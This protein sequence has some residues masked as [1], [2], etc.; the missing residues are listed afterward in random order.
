VIIVSNTSPL[1]NLAAI[2]QFHLL[3]DL[4]G[5]LLIANGVWSELNAYNRQWPGSQEVATASWIQ[6]KSPKNQQVILALRR[7]LDQG[8][9][10]TIALA[11]EVGADLVLLDERDGRYAAKRFGL[12]VAGVLGI[13]IEAKQNNLIKQI[14]PSLDALRQQAGFYIHESLYQQV[15]ELSGES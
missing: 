7:D 4:Y 13:L 8:E 9:A 12:Q 3:K 10:E 1:T 11:L 2:G 5:Q 14:K 6:K 15:L